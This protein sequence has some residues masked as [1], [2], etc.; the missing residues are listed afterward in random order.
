MNV[1]NLETAQALVK[2]SIDRATSL[3][4]R[5]ICVA[6][7]DAA[8]LLVAF[9][10]MDGAPAR[11]IAIAQGKAYSAVRMGTSTQAFLARLQREGLQASHFCDPALTP[12]PGGT[13]L[14]LGSGAV[15]GAIGI[16]GLAAE[17]DQQLSDGLAADFGT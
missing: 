3:Y 5:P 14:K 11:S 10:R 15:V 1:L 2:T 4:Q 17:E 12:L 6:V 16:S 13:P 8:G 7:V 9:A